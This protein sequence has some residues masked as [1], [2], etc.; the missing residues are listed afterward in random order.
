MHAAHVYTLEGDDPIVLDT[1][2]ISAN[3]RQIRPT[4]AK[5]LSDNLSEVL[6]GRLSVEALIAH[7]RKVIPRKVR[8]HV[9]LRNDLSEDHTVVHVVTDDTPGLLYLMT[10]LLS[11][12][13][14]EI[15][16]AKI[17]TWGGR[18]EDV[19]YVTRVDGT[20]VP[21]SELPVLEYSLGKELEE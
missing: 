20:K 18:A 15:H 6:S 21:D 3:G 14:M 13:R 17:A 11:R 19:F 12:N 10:T 9:R 7:A 1:L 8:A 4:R 2:W 16:S 5:R